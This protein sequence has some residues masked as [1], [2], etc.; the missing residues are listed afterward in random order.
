[1]DTKG[2]KISISYCF[3]MERYM[4]VVKSDSTQLTVMT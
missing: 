3:Q 1:L 4:V 2:P